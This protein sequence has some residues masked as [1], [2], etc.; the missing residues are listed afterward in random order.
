MKENKIQESILTLKENTI[1]S[2]K[3]YRKGQKIRIKESVDPEDIFYQYHDED[4]KSKNETIEAMVSRGGIDYDE[5][6]EI[7]SKLTGVK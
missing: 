5:A 3:A 4:G 2:G 1:I 6:E 7:Y